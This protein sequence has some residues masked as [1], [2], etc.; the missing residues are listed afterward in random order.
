M[1]SKCG[2][3]PTHH[4]SPWGIADLFHYQKSF[5]SVMSPEDLDVRLDDFQGSAIK[6]KKKG[7][8]IFDAIFRAKTIL[9]NGEK[10]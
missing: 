10:K 6:K 9:R 5:V 3:V 7:K 1:A 4:N 2:D 8:Q